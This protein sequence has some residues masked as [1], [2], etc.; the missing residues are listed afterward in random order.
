MSHEPQPYCEFISF[1]ASL[2]LA[3]ALLRLSLAEHAFEWTLSIR[4]FLCSICSFFIWIG[5]WLHS[6]ASKWTKCIFSLP[7]VSVHARP[8]QNISN[9]T[10]TQSDRKWVQW[11]LTRCNCF[12]FSHFV[13]HSFVVFGVVSLLRRLIKMNQFCI[14]SSTKTSMSSSSS[15]AGFPFRCNHVK[16]AVDHVTMK[17]N[18][19]NFCRSQYFQKQNECMTWFMTAKCLWAVLFRT[20]AHT[21]RCRQLN[22]FIVA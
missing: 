14:I 7:Y 16:I 22:S 12:C 13:L 4:F 19:N 6:I 15:S 2:S 20:R 10:E 17:G 11:T 9:T 3:R 1:S 8:T 5:D 21:L 18:E